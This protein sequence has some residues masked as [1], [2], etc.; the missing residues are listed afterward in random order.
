MK[1]VLDTN[2]WVSA[3]LW[4]GIPG[5]IIRLGRTREITICTSEA[6]LAEL[7]NT[8]SYNKLQ[9]KIQ[10]LNFT[11]DQLMIGT[12]ELVEIYVIGELNLPGLRDPD[13]IIVLA[14]AIAA[15]ADVIITGDRDL[16][17]LAEYQGIN[18][19]TARDFWQR[20]FDIN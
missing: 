6:L 18:I 1:I 19:M 13:D 10:S 9:Q 2:V 5:N 11:K 17:I 7:E 15:K 14:T 16:L 20:Y 4:R 12:R 3:W 8:L